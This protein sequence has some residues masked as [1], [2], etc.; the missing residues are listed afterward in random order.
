LARN[1]T[2]TENAAR[3]YNQAADAY[4]GYADGDPKHLFSFEGHHAYADRQ[5]WSV[6]DTRLRELH[7]AGTTSISLLDAGCGPGTRLLRL[8]AHARRLGFSASLREALMSPRPRFMLRGTWRM[9]SLSCRVWLSHSK[10]QILRVGCR[11]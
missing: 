7:A 1:D 3:V 11:R 2:A 8:V 6:L 5:V 9:I 4:L 10:L